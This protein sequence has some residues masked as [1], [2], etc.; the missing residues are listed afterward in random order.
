MSEKNATVGDQEI[1]MQTT[2]CSLMLNNFDNIMSSRIPIVDL[3][4]SED[5]QRPAALCEHNGFLNLAWP[6]PTFNCP[7][8]ILEFS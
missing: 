8:V 3:S 2:I 4:F 6:L 1:N 7:V 5:H